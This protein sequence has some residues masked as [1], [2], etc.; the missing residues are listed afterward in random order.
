MKKWILFVIFLPLVLASNQQVFSQEYQDS[1]LYSIETLDGNEYIGKIISVDHEKITLLTENLGEIKIFTKDLKRIK[2][3]PETSIKKGRYWFE[4]PQATRY[5]WA[6]N[7]YG[8]KK[9]EGYYQNVWIFFNQVSVGVTDNFSIG[10][11]MVPAFIFAGAPTPVWITPKFSIPVAK[12]KFNVGLGTLAGTVIGESGATFGILYGSTTFGSK[13]RNL[14]LG[15]GYGFAGGEWAEGPAI[16][17]SGMW[18][19]GPRGYLITENYFIGLG[20]DEFGLL[21]FGARRIIKKVSLDFGGFI[22]FS[23]DTSFFIIPWLGI[24]VAIGRNR[25]IE[26]P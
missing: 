10:A 7:G 17:V 8:L 12:D 11:G 21:S 22:P 2:E 15:L 18:R 16:N 13:D 20:G 6:P 1:V 19:T 4:N 5:F 26:V 3:V 23:D 14:T 25:L 24:S 9:G